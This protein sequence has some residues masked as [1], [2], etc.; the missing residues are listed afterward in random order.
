MM[1]LSQLYEKEGRGQKLND[2]SFQSFPRFPQTL[3]VEAK[4]FLFV[5]LA[6]FGRP[7]VPEV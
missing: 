3:G 5:S 1:I 7:V 6:P 4:I 2:F